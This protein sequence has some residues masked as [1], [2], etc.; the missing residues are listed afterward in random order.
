MRQLKA[1]AAM[2]LVITLLLCAFSTAGGVNGSSQKLLN[3]SSGAFL[4]KSNGNR[5]SVFE[6]NSS[7]SYSYTFS[8][9]VL[10]YCIS[11]GKLYAAM[12]TNQAGIVLVAS[13]KNGKILGET[14]VFD[15]NNSN[16][17]DISVD[18]AGRIYLVN[19]KNYVSIYN[20]KGQFIRTTDRAYVSV[21][22][23]GGKIYAVN[24]SRIYV[25]GANSDNRLCDYYTGNT[26]Y[27]VSDKYI[28]DTEGNVFDINSRKRILSLGLNKNYSIAEGSKYILALNGNTV[29]AY[30]KS[31][32][33]FVS[34]Y[35]LGFTPFALYADGKNVYV[36]KSGGFAF[37][38]ISQKVFEVQSNTQETQGSISTDSSAKSDSTSSVLNS[39]ISF[40]SYKVSGRFI[41]V[42]AQTKRTDFK[43]AI[44]Y[45]GYDLKFSKSTGLGTGT[46]ATFTKDSKTYTYTFIVM[47]DLTGTGRINSRDIEVMFNCLFG[48]DKVSG[49]YK[50]A[51]DMNGDGKLSNVDLVM[52]DRKTK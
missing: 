14:A 16:N 47:G 28:A 15:K 43:S 52:L 4:C 49:A 1:F 51:A 26:I 50:I 35:T 33:A 12:H 29:S 6:V 10:A 18:S 11:A 8:Y 20:S 9:N 37:K 46:K 7:K 3:D 38:T 40:G 45:D 2:L 13:A 48:I 34:S 36:L 41:Y 21:I 39:N 23:C 22:Q 5:V 24:S 19:N 25:L 44:S 17:T 32:G 31:D 30:S 42:D 27:A